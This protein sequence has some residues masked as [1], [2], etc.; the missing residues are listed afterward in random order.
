MAAFT[1]GSF[2]KAPS[3]ICV[4]LQDIGCDLCGNNLTAASFGELYCVRGRKRK[5][6]EKG[7]KKGGEKVG[8]GG[9]RKGCKRCPL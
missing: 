3:A 5:G 4:S 2:G 8:G 1:D 9:K 6:G 7:E